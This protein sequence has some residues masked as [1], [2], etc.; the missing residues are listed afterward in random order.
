MTQFISKIQ[1]SQAY[2]RLSESIPP[3]LK[4]MSFSVSKVAAPVL[5]LL[6]F[7]ALV[8]YRRTII[9]M[10]TW[11]N[12][13]IPSETEKK[14]TSESNDTDGSASVQ[15][16]AEPPAQNA[17]LADIETPTEETEEPASNT[18]KKQTPTQ[19]PAVVNEDNSSEAT[20]MDFFKQL[21]DQEKL[22]VKGLSQK[23]LVDALVRRPIF[24]DPSMAG[25]ELD[26]DDPS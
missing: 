5:A 23:S 22:T 16:A 20:S 18:Q 10:F 11:N 21:D 25:S 6:A 12:P 26:V 9:Q 4:N 2:Q 19:D 1:F 17:Q 14:S 24:F 3:S 13:P 7:G 15:T 8:Y